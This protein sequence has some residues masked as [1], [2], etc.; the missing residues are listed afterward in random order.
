MKEKYF[1]ASNS[2]RGFCSY[3][4][5]AFDIDKL[6]RIYAIKGGSGTGKAFFMKSVAE[7]A[8]ERGLSVRYVYCSSDPDSLD[9]IIIKEMK[10]AI[11]DGTAPHVYE[12]KIVGAVDSIVDLGAFLNTEMLVK[13]RKIIE[14]IGDAKHRGFENA[15]RYLAAYK[16]ISDNIR[17]L[18]LPCVKLE[19]V[20]KFVDRVVKN[21]PTGEGSEENLLV[22]SIGMKGIASF[23]TYYQGASLYYGVCDYFDVAHVLTDEI[24]RAFKEAK[25]DMMISNN[26]IIPERIDAICSVKNGLTFEIC[27]TER[28]GG[29]SISMKRFVDAS[30]IPSIR[31]QYRALVGVRDDILNLALSELERI[32]KYHFI[33]EEIYGSAMDFEKKEEFTTRFCKKIFQNN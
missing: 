3:Y 21:L 15:Y 32:R 17:F 7:Q 14:K 23:D 9:G 33:L 31:K 30:A 6:R 8:E 1:A 13:S 19:K 25:I 11:L 24:Y 27:N 22:R 29:R 28:D 2:Y 5:N 16:K 12:P 10:T 4:D 26:P 20:R 18:T